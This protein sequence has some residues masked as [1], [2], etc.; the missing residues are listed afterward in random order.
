[1]FV[2]DE[3][4]GHAGGPQLAGE[5][6]GRLQ[7]GTGGG[8]GGDLLGEDP[9]NAVLGQGVELGV[10]RLGLPVRNVSSAANE[11]DRAGQTGKSP[12]TSS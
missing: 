2:D 4:D 9:G 8:A 11:H 12:M 3:G 1:V 10:Q 6:D 7:L 5:P